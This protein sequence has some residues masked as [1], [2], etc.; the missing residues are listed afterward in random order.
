[1]ISKAFI[2]SFLLNFLR[3]LP[4]SNR[5]RSFGLRGRRQSKEFFKLI[6]VSSSLVEDVIKTLC[7]KTPIVVPKAVSNFRDSEA[8]TT[9]L[10]ILMASLAFAPTEN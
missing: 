7:A 5:S 3:I 8:D 10:H 9:G 1:M 4:A 2:G 6:E